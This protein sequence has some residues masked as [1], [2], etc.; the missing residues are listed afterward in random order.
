M[1][2]MSYCRFQNTL[3]DLE[4]CVEAMYDID[5]NFEELS[6]EEARAAKALLDLCNNLVISYY[7]LNDEE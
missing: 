2:N 1:S 4:D 6:P 5:G 7:H 3:R